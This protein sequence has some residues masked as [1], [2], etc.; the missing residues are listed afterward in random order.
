MYEKEKKDLQRLDK[1]DRFLVVSYWHW[2]LFKQTY[3]RQSLPM[4]LVP[5]HAI[6]MLVV[7]LGFPQSYP[8]IILIPVLFAASYYVTLL[9]L[10]IRPQPRAHWV[11]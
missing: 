3:K 9:I 8:D 4:R 5:V 6:F 7:L 1:I 11:K 10:F 2:L